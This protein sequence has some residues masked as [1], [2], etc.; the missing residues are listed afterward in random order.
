MKKLLFITALLLTSLN[1]K[2]NKFETKENISPL[3]K[4]YSADQLIANRKTFLIHAGETGNSGS[5]G[6]DYFNTIKPKVVKMHLNT[7]LLPIY[8]EPIEPV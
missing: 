4:Q 2:T 7:L 3:R 5:S 6:R 1:A 8:Q